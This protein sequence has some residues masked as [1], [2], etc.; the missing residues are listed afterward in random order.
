MTR[1]LL[2]S[3]YDSTFFYKTN[4]S[5]LP[6]NLDAVSRW[7]QQGNVFAISTGRDAASICYE[8]RHR[9]IAF[10]YLVALNGAFIIDSA[11]NVL[12]KQSFAPDIAQTIVESLRNEFNDELIISNGFDGCNFTNRAKS[13]ND[14]IAK[15]VYER[16]ASIYTRSIEQSID[17]EVL[18]IGCLSTSQ[19]Q[20]HSVKQRILEQHSTPTCSSTQITSTLFL[21]GSRRRAGLT[22]SCNMLILPMLT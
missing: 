7:Q 15:E 5:L 6:Q 10:D 22:A 1:K 20:A 19:T 17:N 21:K 16:N 2:A 3:D 18:L 14:P 4:P 11:K 8:Q 13:Q 12:F 9:G